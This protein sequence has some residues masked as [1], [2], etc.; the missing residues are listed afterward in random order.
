[1]KKDETNIQELYDPID[2]IKNQR[3]YKNI[4][5]VFETFEAFQDDSLQYDT[6]FDYYF[7]DDIPDEWSLEEQERSHGYGVLEKDETPKLEKFIAIWIDTKAKNYIE[8]F[9]TVLKDYNEKYKSLSYSFEDDILKKYYASSAFNLK[10]F[11][12]EL[13]K[14]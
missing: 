1:M 4:I 10:T 12:T 5:E 3:I 7:S 14:L 2:L 11:Q 8:N 9:S 13:D 6:F